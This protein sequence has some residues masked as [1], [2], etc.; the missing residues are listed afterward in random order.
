MKKYLR[1]INLNDT[2]RKDISKGKLTYIEGCKFTEEEVISWNKY[3]LT[4]DFHTLFEETKMDLYIQNYDDEP[5]FLNNLLSLKREL[6][7]IKTFLQAYASDFKIAYTLINENISL[8]KEEITKYKAKDA[9]ISAKNIEG[10]RMGD[11]SSGI[12]SHEEAG[13]RA[14]VKSLI[15]PYISEESKRCINEVNSYIKQMFTLLYIKFEEILYINFV[16][17]YIK[18]KILNWGGKFEALKKTISLSEEEI[19]IAE[20]LIMVSNHIKHQEPISIMDKV[21][22]IEKVKEFLDRV[23]IELLKLYNYSELIIEIE[24]V[25]YEIEGIQNPL[26]LTGF[27]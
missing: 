14:M 2:Y 19:K 9:I 6:L 18:P 17:L 26:G 21:Y 4:N 11:M 27:E 7:F 12:F 3:I 1:G 23:Y 5:D 15:N 8:S 22:D 16:S 13:N 20:S 24:N 25:Y 10:Q